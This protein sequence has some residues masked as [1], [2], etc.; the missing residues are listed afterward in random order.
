MKNVD[1]VD[2]EDIVRLVQKPYFSISGQKNPNS[3]KSYRGPKRIITEEVNEL[4]N[5]S[6]FEVMCV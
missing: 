6:S 5:I 3:G 4:W 2:S 1:V